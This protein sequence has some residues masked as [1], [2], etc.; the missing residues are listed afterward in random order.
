MRRIG[1][2]LFKICGKMF[3]ATDLAAYV[4]YFPSSLYVFPGVTGEHM[5]NIVV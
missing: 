1:M 5:W 4:P 2:V 3:T